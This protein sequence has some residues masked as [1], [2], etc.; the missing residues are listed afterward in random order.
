MKKLLIAL[1]AGTAVAGDCSLCYGE[2]PC[3][4]DIDEGFV[5]LFNGKDLAGWVGATEMYGVET[6]KETMRGTKREKESKVL[7]CVPERHVKGAPANLIFLLGAEIGRRTLYMA[8]GDA[9]QHL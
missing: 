2:E 5:S 9:S 1:A 8:L 3:T 6:I 7:A 4:E